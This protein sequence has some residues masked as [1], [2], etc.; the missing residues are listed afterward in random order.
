MN[1][2]YLVAAIAML[3]ICAPSFGTDASAKSKKVRP[4]EGKIVSDSQKSD[5]YSKLSAGGKHQKGMIGIWEMDDK[6]YFEIPDSLIGKEMLGV[7]RNARMAMDL[8]FSGEEHDARIYTW[9]KRNDK[10]IHFTARSYRK[11]ADPD[12]D[13]YPAV[14]NCMEPTII[15]SFES[16]GT[17]PDG[18][19]IIDVTDLF[20]KDY[21]VY[22]LTPDVKQKFTIKG[23]EDSNCYIEEMKSFPENVEILSTKTY[24]VGSGSKFLENEGLGVVTAAFHTSL[25]LLPQKPLTP[26]KADYRVG[27][28]TN[29]HYDYSNNDSQHAERMNYACRWRLEPKDKKAYFAGELVEP[30]KPITL[31]LSPSIPKKWIP[32][33]IQG[34]EDWQPAFEAAGFKNAIVAK[35]FPSKEENPDFDPFDARYSVVEYF[36]S[37]VENSYGPHV[38]DPRT[39]EI[40]NTHVCIFHNALKLLHDWYTLQCG[41]A[42]SRA[43]TMI[44][45][46]ALMGRL[47]RYLVCHEVGHTLGLMHN[48]GASSSYPVDSLRS[49]TFTTAHGTTSSIMDYARFNYVA[50]P[51]DGEVGRFPIVGEY[52]KFAIEWGYRLYPDISDP[53]DERLILNNYIKDKQK[54]PANRYIRQFLFQH[55]PRGQT[56]D[57]GDDPV[58]AATYGLKNLKYA[59]DNLDKW[60]YREGYNYADLQEMYNKLVKQWTKYLRHVEAVISGRY[61]DYKTADQEGYVYTDVSK[62]D[63]KAAIDFLSENIIIL[64]K[65]IYAQPYLRNIDVF[66]LNTRKLM[67]EQGRAVK[68]MLTLGT[69]IRMDED[70]EAN[71]ANSYNPKDYMRDVRKAV[72]KDLYGNTESDYLLRTVE[73]TY[74][75][76]LE[77]HLKFKTKGDSPVPV[78]LKD[79]EYKSRIRADLRLLLQDLKAARTANPEQQQHYKECIDRINEALK[80]DFATTK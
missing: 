75:T 19:A 24:K 62:E 6:Y 16:K 27:F 54:D 2:S 49:I 17:T 23:I 35:P 36:P 13:M 9:E 52:D 43:R 28:F 31:Y 51:E 20:R 63:K 40:I 26:R 79:L 42:D 69:L 32:Y 45:D 11:V 67:D 46:D 50:Q 65:W 59:A 68:S 25:L 70:W 7:T 1:K 37:Y 78:D 61:E 66:K 3:A 33:F 56:E 4:G 48:F 72:W 38:S 74:L 73:R 14:R 5:F 21:L 8:G 41:A 77:N 34:I 39:G 18:A 55:D 30:V 53:E 80:P 57:L 47:V 64:P 15:M 58:K 76:L 71:P 44:Y 12:S 29:R 60:T 22:E 10:I